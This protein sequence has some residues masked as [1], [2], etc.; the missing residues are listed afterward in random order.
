M[1]II[2]RAEALGGYRA[3]PATGHLRRRILGPGAGQAASK[4]ASPPLFAGEIALV[5]GA[6]SGIGKA[7]VDALLARG[8]AVVGLDINPAI[9]IAVQAPDF[10]GLRC[11]VTD[12]GDVIAALEA[13]V[14][15]FGGLDMLVLNAGIFPAGAAHRRRSRRMPNGAR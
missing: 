12:G 5:T 13:G 1:D 2:L 8:A 14:A 6:A 11:D 3:L 10:L 9:E 4:A 15:R 7:C